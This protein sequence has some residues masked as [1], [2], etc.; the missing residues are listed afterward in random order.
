MAFFTGSLSLGLESLA[1]VYPTI[2]I[3]LQLLPI[4]A[5]FYGAFY[6]GAIYLELIL[7]VIL[8]GLGSIVFGISLIRYWNNV[9]GTTP[10]VFLLAVWIGGIVWSR[11]EIRENHGKDIP[12]AYLM[13]APPVFGF[14]CAGCIAL[15]RENVLLYDVLRERLDGQA[16]WESLLIIPALL[17]VGLPCVTASAVGGIVQ[18]WVGAFAYRLHERR[19][20]PQ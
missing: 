17:M 13:L 3:T 5:I 14:I 18:G 6:G 15:I 4:L 16:R 11:N 9:S 10:Y 2:V 8:G 7:E 20:T 12:R 1:W 19:S